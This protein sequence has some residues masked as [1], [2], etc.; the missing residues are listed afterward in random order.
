MNLPNLYNL[1]FSDLNPLTAK[2]D[3]KVITD[4]GESEKVLATKGA[5]VYAFAGQYPVAWVYAFKEEAR[6]L[7]QVLPKC[8]LKKRISQL[9]ATEKP[10]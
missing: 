10:L 3:D 7:K 4:N 9:H 5:A 8:R 2:L 1:A 6:P